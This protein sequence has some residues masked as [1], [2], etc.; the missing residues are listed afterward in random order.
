MTDYSFARLIKAQSENK[1]SFKLESQFDNN[2]YQSKSE[3][4]S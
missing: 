3:K 4:Y 2:Y 1:T